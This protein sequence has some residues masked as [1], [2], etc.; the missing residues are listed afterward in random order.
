MEAV[1]TFGLSN[2]PHDGYSKNVKDKFGNLKI[3]ARR[4]R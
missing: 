2:Q 4:E 1:G 3:P